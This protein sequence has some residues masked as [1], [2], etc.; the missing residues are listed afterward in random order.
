[1]SLLELC[2]WRIAQEPTRQGVL[3][4]KMSTVLTDRVLDLILGDPNNQPL[5]A[6]RLWV[7]L[8][9]PIVS[10]SIRNCLVDD[11]LFR[12]INYYKWTLKVLCFERCEF[13]SKKYKCTLET[14]RLSSLTIINC[15]NLTDKQYKELFERALKTTRNVQIS[16][17]LHLSDTFIYKPVY[18]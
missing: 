18:T 11:R 10:L 7:S 16:H 17:C 3:S 6:I 1:M 12:V 8:R 2:L 15:N 5:L 14:E 13:D 4:G 9:L